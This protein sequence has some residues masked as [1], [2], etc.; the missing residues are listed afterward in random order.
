MRP[1]KA[2]LSPIAPTLLVLL[3]SARL[4]SGGMQVAHRG[5]DMPFQVGVSPTVTNGGGYSSID[6]TQWNDAALIQSSTGCVDY[7][8]DFP[9]C[10][11]VPSPPQGQVKIYSKRDR[12]G[13]FMYLLFDVDDQTIPTASTSI[14]DQII[15]QIDTNPSGAK[16]LTSSTF[17]LQYQVPRSSQGTSNTTWSQGGATNQVPAWN[18]IAAP[19]NL[20]IAAGNRPD[21]TGYRVAIQIPL[22]NPRPGLGYDLT[23]HDFQDFGIA[24]AVINDIG[25]NDPNGFEYLT[26]A[27]FPNQ[28]TAQNLGGLSLSNY[29]DPLLNALESGE[30]GSS[31]SPEVNWFNPSLWA[32]G[33]FRG[34]GNTVFISQLPNFYSSQDIKTTYCNVAAFGDVIGPGQPN[35]NWYQYFSGAPARWGRSP[36]SR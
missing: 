23:A 8:T 10:V 24:I 33:I 7:L 19:A 13:Q 21:N 9:N 1:A 3:L 22:V 14:G 35:S 18:P 15:I 16:L 34:A 5:C 4:A 36:S 28:G 32:A 31:G 25:C 12:P 6:I 26:G 27:A 29:Q 20:A 2:V 17:R 30:V 11:I